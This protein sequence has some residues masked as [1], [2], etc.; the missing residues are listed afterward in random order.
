M[1]IIWSD[2]A[3]QQLDEIAEYVQDN[4]GESTSRKMVHKITEDV[5]RLKIY[6]S[7]GK[8]D[9]EYFSKHSNSDLQVRQLLVFPNL[10]YYLE[11]SERIDIICIRKYG[12]QI[13]L[14]AWHS[15]EV[16]EPSTIFEA[17]DGAYKP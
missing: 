1:E 8:P 13:P 14:G 4:F 9:F 15:V 17:K 6:P 3:I 7:I 10:V 5:N 11:R 16:Y 2:L 12:V